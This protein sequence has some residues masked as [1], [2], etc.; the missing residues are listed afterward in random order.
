MARRIPVRKILRLRAS[1]LLASVI[2]RMQLVSKTSVIDTFHAA[3]K[4]GVAWEDV[5]GNVQ[6]LAHFDSGIASR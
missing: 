1:G 2:A 4:R 3:D 6:F 5:E